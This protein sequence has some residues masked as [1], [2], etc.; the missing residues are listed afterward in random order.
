MVQFLTI[1]ESEFS[2]ERRKLARNFADN[3]LEAYNGV[4]IPMNEDQALDQSESAIREVL[5][6]GQQTKNHFFYYIVNENNKPVGHIWF[7]IED[8]FSGKSAFLYMIYI[9]DDERGKSYAHKA[10]DVLRE[11]VTTKFGIHEIQ[12]NVHAY[13]KTAIMLYEKLGFK[14]LKMTMVLTDTQ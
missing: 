8:E 11:T 5:P 6:N 9:N 1:P 7:S 2:K 3:L 4:G 14:P 12:L 10:M 13:N